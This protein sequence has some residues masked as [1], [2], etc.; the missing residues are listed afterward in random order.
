MISLRRII[1]AGLL[2]PAVFCLLSTNGQEANSPPDSST[3]LTQTITDEI[4]KD[5][6]ALMTLDRSVLWARLGETWWKDD[7]ERARAWL[8]KAVQELE[9]A[10]TDQENGSDRQ[11]RLD[12]ARSLLSIISPRDKALSDRLMAIFKP[13]ADHVS[14]ADGSK[15][16]SA[17][18]DNA[19]AILNA[20]PQR[21]IELG[22]ESLRAGRTPR[23]GSLLGAL[24][25]RVGKSSDDLFVETLE[26]ARVNYDRQVLATLA[27]VAFK[28]AAPSDDL[29]RRLLQ[30]FA[31]GLLHPITSSADE[32]VAC[33]LASNAA[34]L[35]NEFDRLLPQQAGLVRLAITR[36]RPLLQD[37]EQ[38][39]VN[40]SLSDQSLN[41]VEAILE[42]ASKAPD[43]KTRDSYLGRAAYMA[44]QEKSFD[45]AISILDDISSEGQEQMGSTWD[46]WRWEYT[47]S[48]ALAR[49][50]HADRLGMY[51]VITGTPGKLRPF[52]Q[53]SVARDLIKLGDRVTATELAGEARKGLAQADTSDAA[54]GYLSLIRL[55]AQLMPSVTPT[56]FSETVAVMNRGKQSSSSSGIFLK[57]DSESLSLSNDI[58][59]R[60]FS[61]PISLLEIDNVGVRHAISSI[62][63]PFKRAAIRLNFLNLLLERRRIAPPA[64]R[65][66]VSKG[67]EDGNQ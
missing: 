6:P 38:Q 2:I 25:R 37:W 64:K 18:I 48:A 7:P 39:V 65:P 11:R 47:S 35:M 45:H 17:L 56:V 22:S 54:D 20:D 15:N 46:S 28:G 67:K 10:Q 52:V 55:Y 40:E 33:N 63:S 41:T 9:V 49:Y 53:I 51:H 27:A 21:A 43:S 23:I 36:C 13:D 31:E 50:K 19:L 34:S 12:T 29:R 4:V 26:V 5:A 66:L 61:L 14:S 16:A 58:L 62:E 24:R 30:V 60:S 59:F 44:G 3:L 1:G 32:A 8:L 42:A 57:G